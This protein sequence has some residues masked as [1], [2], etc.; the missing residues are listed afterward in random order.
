LINE[1]QQAKIER[2]EFAKKNKEL[3]N[4]LNEVT[5]QNRNMMEYIQT[6]DTNNKTLAIKKNS[7]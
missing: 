3:L 1:L 7:N 2:Q 6:G 4:T 5:L